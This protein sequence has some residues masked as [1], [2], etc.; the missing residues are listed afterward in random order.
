MHRRGA[1]RA[2]E[3]MSRIRLGIVRYASVA[4]AIEERLAT[5]GRIACKVGSGRF[6]VTLR[7][8]GATEWEPASRAAYAVE[9]AAIAR[10]VLAAHPRATVR[11]QA[12]RAVVVRLED[13]AVTR[14]CQVRTVWECVVPVSSS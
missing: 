6:Y 12:R 5:G 11:R 14:G 9:A 1:T 2:V 3:P 13:A 10:E 8:V 7:G 4:N